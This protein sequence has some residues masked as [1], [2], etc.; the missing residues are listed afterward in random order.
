[1]TDTAT[2]PI[3]LV[4]AAKPNHGWV[5]VSKTI[6]TEN[7]WHWRDGGL[8]A[9]FIKNVPFPAQDLA[10]GERLARKPIAVKFTQE[11]DAQLRAMNN[12]QAFIRQAVA[13]KLEKVGKERQSNG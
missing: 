6:A 10:Q 1:M 8:S 7:G 2:P 9:G 4:W 5:K 11:V 12:R 13:E 3:E